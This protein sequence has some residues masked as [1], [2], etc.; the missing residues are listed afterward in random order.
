MAP[1]RYHSV[2]VTPTLSVAL[3]ATLAVPVRVLPAVGELN[4]TDGAVASPTVFCTVTLTTAELLLLP[5]ASYARAYKVHEPFGLVVV[6]QENDPAAL[7]PASALFTY[8]STLLTTMLSEEATLTETVPDSVLP[9]VG[10]E[11]IAVGGFVTLVVGAAPFAAST[12]W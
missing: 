2:L 10:A 9:L 7:V 5:A 8:N 1:L 11:T 3:T 4:C 12:A 6:F